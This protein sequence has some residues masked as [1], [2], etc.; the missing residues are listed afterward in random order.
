MIDQ[1]KRPVP[2]Q[3]QSDRDKP[4]GAKDQGIRKDERGQEQPAD[5]RR[6]QENR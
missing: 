4:D 5:K 3:P 6:A 1:P 2:A